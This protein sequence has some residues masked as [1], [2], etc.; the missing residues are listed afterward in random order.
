[1]YSDANSNAL[2]ARGQITT[3]KGKADDSGQKK[4]SHNRVGSKSVCMSSKSFQKDKDLMLHITSN[5]FWNEFVT[6]VQSPGG[7]SS[8]F[9]QGMQHHTPVGTPEQ[10]ATR[11]PSQP[12]PIIHTLRI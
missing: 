12:F 3:G 10:F 4:E 7:D 8:L 5:T 11:F 6:F 2:V 9:M 1:M